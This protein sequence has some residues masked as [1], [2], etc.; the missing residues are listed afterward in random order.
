V[1]AEDPM[2]N[3]QADAGKITR[4]RSPGGPGIRIDSSIHAG[5]SIPPYYDSMIAKL[6][7]R[8]MTREETIARMRRAITEYVIIGVKTTLPLQYA[9]MNNPDFIAGNTHTHFLQDPEITKYLARYMRESETRM[10]QLGAPLKQGKEKTIAVTAA[11]SAYMSALA[12][13]NGQ[14]KK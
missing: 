13:K 12:A 7:A 1:N 8:A 4:Y 2:N 11:V 6:C 14:N 3:Y 5:Y 9:V 10:N